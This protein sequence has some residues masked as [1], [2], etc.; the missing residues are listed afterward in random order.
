LRHQAL[1]NDCATAVARKTSSTPKLVAD[2]VAARLARLRQPF[3]AA[4]PGGALGFM[5]R[6][7]TGKAVT[8][9]RPDGCLSFASCSGTE[10]LCEACSLRRPRAESATPKVTCTY[11]NG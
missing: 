5:Y 9:N 8:P 11:R 7:K 3:V 6:D 1:S 10:Q 2:P 4:L